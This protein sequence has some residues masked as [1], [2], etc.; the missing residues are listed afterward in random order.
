MKNY[1]LI[2]KTLGHSFS[3]N[4]F[5]E[6]FMAEHI[7]AQYDLYEIPAI[8]QFPLLVKQHEF[9]GLNVT[10]PYKEEIIQYL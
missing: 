8:C 10:I 2:G 3:K 7:D 4:F 5:T 9:S 6:K 1:G